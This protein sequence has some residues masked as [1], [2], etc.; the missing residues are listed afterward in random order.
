MGSKMVAVFLGLLLATV[1]FISSEVE[2]KELADTS[3]TSKVAEKTSG[4]LAKGV[5]IP[6]GGNTVGG[7]LKSCCFWFKGIC[8]R[9]C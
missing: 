3:K 6:P 2:A 8:G 1:L 9:M 7:N 5:G 4:I